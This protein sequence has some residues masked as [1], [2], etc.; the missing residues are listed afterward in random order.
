MLEVLPNRSQ[1]GLRFPT[2]FLGCSYR[3]RSRCPIAP[4][5][6]HLS[7]QSVQGRTEVLQISRLTYG[8]KRVTRV[9]SPL[10]QMLSA[11]HCVV[12]A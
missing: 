1:R 7:T 8:G 4:P 2:C 10:H 6:A 12:Q 3:L 9:S 11:D 5:H